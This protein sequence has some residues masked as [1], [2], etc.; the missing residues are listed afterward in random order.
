MPPVPLFVRVVERHDAAD[1][2]RRRWPPQG[3]GAAPVEGG[4]HRGEESGAL[5]SGFRSL[6]LCSVH[7]VGIEMQPQL[8]RIELT[9]ILDFHEISE[10]SNRACK[11][12]KRVFRE[13]NSVGYPFKGTIDCQRPLVTTY[14]DC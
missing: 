14:V 8:P 3:R 13:T 9:V 12:K 5:L 11:P 6:V 10:V 7:V 1:G 4:E 2:G